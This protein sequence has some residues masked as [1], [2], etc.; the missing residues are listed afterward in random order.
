MQAEEYLKRIGYTG[1]REPNA[2]TLKQLHRAH[3]FS[4]PFENLDIFLGHPIVLSLPS[5][6]DKIVGRR[7]ESEWEPQYLFSL[8]PH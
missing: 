1:S 8:T 3:M 7:R 6:Y 4:A 2:D 5:F